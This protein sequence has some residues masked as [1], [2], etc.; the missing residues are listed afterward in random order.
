M[1]TTGKGILVKMTFGWLYSL[2]TYSDAEMEGMF[3]KAGFTNIRIKSTLGLM[4][5]CYG[6]RPV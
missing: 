3:G 5:V 2:R 4:Q 1:A 6:E